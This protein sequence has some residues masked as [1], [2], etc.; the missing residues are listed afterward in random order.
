M[1][2]R[3]RKVEQ[4]YIDGCFQRLLLSFAL[5]KAT[6]TPSFH[7][8]ITP[9][10][11]ARQNA[12]ARR[13]HACRRRRFHR[14]AVAAFIIHAAMYAVACRHVPR[15]AISR[16]RHRAAAACRVTPKSHAARPPP[17]HTAIHAPRP[18]PSSPPPRTDMPP[19]WPMMLAFI[20]RCRH[21]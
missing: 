10:H 14:P 20:S 15:H 16:R 21:A 12:A 2:K 9:R 18:P 5:S 8:V 13:F 3:T 4:V 6:S 11:A 19:C 7:L 1:V 17:F